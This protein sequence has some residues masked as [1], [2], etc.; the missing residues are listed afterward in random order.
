MTAEKKAT[1]IPGP[2]PEHKK[3]AGVFGLGIS[4]S[5]ISTNYLPQ[6]GLTP[7]PPIVDNSGPVPKKKESEIENED[8]EHEAKS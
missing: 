5:H 2:L 4:P 6:S 1:E 7:I 8:E 3:D